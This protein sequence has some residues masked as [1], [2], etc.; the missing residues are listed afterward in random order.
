MAG[1]CL[2]RPG[3]AHGKPALVLDAP[4]LV[5][6]NLEHMIVFSPA[7]LGSLEVRLDFGGLRP[8]GLTK[9][10]ERYARANPRGPELLTTDVKAS[11]T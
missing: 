6:N 2:A 10:R 7:S 8:P 9:R 5:K 11:S 3:Q 4:K 1:D